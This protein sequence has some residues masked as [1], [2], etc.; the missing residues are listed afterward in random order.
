MIRF[1][2]LIFKLR[3]KP[4]IRPELIDLT[5]HFRIFVIMIG[6]NV[7]SPSKNEF[8]FDLEKYTTS[9]DFTEERMSFY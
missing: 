7:S 5:I 6:I 8:Q 9:N 1:I 3:V 4:I 2:R